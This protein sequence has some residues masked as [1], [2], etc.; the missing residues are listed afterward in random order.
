MA[1]FLTAQ[2][3]QL[4]Q[5]QKKI[6]FY[7]NHLNNKFLNINLDSY[8][9]ELSHLNVCN[10]AGFFINSEIMFVER[11]HLKFEHAITINV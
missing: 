7:P 4:I 6:S 3:K 10:N 11:N 8:E 1:I 5:L 9:G 2:L